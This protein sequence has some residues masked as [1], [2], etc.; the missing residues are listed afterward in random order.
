MVKHSKTNKES[1]SKSVEDDSSP[2]QK[3]VKHHHQIT[4]EKLLGESNIKKDEEVIDEGKLILNKIVG[5]LKGKFG[6]DMRHSMLLQSPHNKSP[7]LICLPLSPHH[8]HPPPTLQEHHPKTT[9][10]NLLTFI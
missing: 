6:D 3:S 9:L 2:S 10:D 4:K 8:P 5:M 7:P 1:R